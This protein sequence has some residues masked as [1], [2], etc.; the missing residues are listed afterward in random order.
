MAT[1]GTAAVVIFNY[2]I[3]EIQWERTDGGAV[4]AGIN[5]GDGT[6]SFTIGSSFEQHDA[7]IN[8]LSQGNTGVEGQWVFRVDDITHAQPGRKGNHVRLHSQITWQF[9]HRA[10][11]YA[12]L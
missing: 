12:L 10:D 6:H 5:A 4:L 3:D 2:D 7:I 1:D 8:K 11:E 9:N